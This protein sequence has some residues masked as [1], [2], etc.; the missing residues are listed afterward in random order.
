M[1]IVL[2]Y[3]KLK[4]PKPS[5]PVQELLFFTLS[6]LLIYL[7][8]H[9]H[10]QGLYNVQNGIIVSGE[11]KELKINHSGSPNLC[12]E[13]QNYDIR[14]QKF[15]KNFSKDTQSL[16]KPMALSHLFLY[17]VVADSV[18]RHRSP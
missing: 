6:A 16:S 4:L 8:T 15:K 2:K 3:E 12:T 10:K 1:T 13:S 18:R 5:G 14:N 7:T 17:S 9:N 11:H